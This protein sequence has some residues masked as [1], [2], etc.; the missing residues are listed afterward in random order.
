VVRNATRSGFI[1]DN[2]SVNSSVNL[3]VDVTIYGGCADQG[4]L[5]GANVTSSTFRAVIASIYGIGAIESE[6]SGSLRQRGNSYTI[7]SKNCGLQSCVIGGDSGIWDISSTEDGRTGTQGSSFAV[8][9]KGDHNTLYVGLTDTAPWQVRGIVFR[10]GADYNR[11]VS[12]R[13]TNTANPLSDSGIGNITVGAV[14][15]TG[16]TASTGT[17]AKGAYATYAGQTVSGSYTQTEVQATDNAVKALSQRLKA[18]E[19]T[20]R[21][22]GVIG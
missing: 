18:I 8:D 14:P 4:L 21:L 15:D 11:L 3:V 19:D 2:Q 22:A 17:A 16:W 9:V 6:Q 13:Y 10:S 7:I 5:V 20:L 1:C 12:Y